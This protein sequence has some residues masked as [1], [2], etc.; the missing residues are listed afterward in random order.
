MIKKLIAF[1]ESWTNGKELLEIEPDGVTFPHLIANELNLEYTCYA[2][3]NASLLYV[4]SDLNDWV[5]SVSNE[6]MNETFVLIGLP[7]ET[8]LTE[9]LST[10]EQ[11]HL[12]ADVVNNIHEMAF[13]LDLKLLQVNVM[14]QIREPKISSLLNKLSLLEILILRNRPRK[15]PLLLPLKNPNT[16]GHRTLSEHLLPEVNSV[17]IA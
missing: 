9:H 6:E 17:I 7:S 3:D 10:D 4:F 8:I 2:R 12:Y 14:T 1:G 11:K 15:N 16:E 13:Q 5:E